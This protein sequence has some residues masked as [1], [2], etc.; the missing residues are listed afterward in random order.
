MS[1][2]TKLKQFKDLRQ[3]GKKM[4]GLLQG[5]AATGQAAGNK[6][7][8]TL[9]GNLAMSG[10]A[11]DP[12]LLAPAEKTRLETAIKDA[13][14]EALKKVQRMVAGKMQQSGD[15]KLPGMS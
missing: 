5:V 13:H 7:V 14:N 3:Q 2:V 10:I 9:D 15:F 11:I 6:V 1:L 8:I 12:G 4:Q